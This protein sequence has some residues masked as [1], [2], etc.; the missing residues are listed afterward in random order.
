VNSFGP[1]DTDMIRKPTI[2]VNTGELCD[3][4]FQPD[5]SIIPVKHAKGRCLTFQASWYSKYPWLHFSV[6]LQ[7]ILCFYCSRAP[8][9]PDSHPEPAFITKGFRNWRKA[10]EKFDTHQVSDFHRS[11]VNQG[12]ANTSVSALLVKG[13]KDRQSFARRMLLMLMTSLRFLARQGLAVR[14][15]EDKNGNFEQLLLLRQGDSEELVRWMKR[16]HTFTSPAIQNE[17]LGL[18]AHS[19]IRQI[20]SEIRNSGSFSAIVDGTQ[21]CN[22]KEQESICIRYVDKDLKPVELFFGLYNTDSTTGQSLS[23]LILDALIRLD[24][25]MRMVRGQTYDGASNMS[26]IY[27]GAQSLIRQ[28]C[29]LATFVHCGSHCTNLVAQQACESSPVVRNA[30]S[31]V[32]ELG[33]LMHQSGKS[34]AVLQNIIS[35][36][37]PV[38]IEAI[39]PLCPTRWTIRVAAITTVLGQL[40]CLLD[41]LNEISTGNGDTAI[42]AR[43]LCDKFSSGDTILALLM[44]LVVFEPLEE[45]CKS[46][47]ARTQTVSGMKQAADKV[48]AFLQTRRS[49]E[50]FSSVYANANGIIESEELDEITVPRVRKAPKRL[51]DGSAPHAAPTPEAHYRAEYYKLVDS[52]I[53]QLKDRFSQ[54]GIDDVM[55]MESCLLQKDANLNFLEKYPEIDISRL[56]VQLQ[57]FQLDNNFTTIREAADFLSKLSPECSQMLSQVE[58]LIRLLL[59]IPASSA[60]AERSFSTLR[61]LKTW[62]RATMTQARLNFL[63]VLNVHSDILDTLNLLDVAEQFVA[64]HDSRLE[65]FGKFATNKS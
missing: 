53:T 47:Q 52:A 38:S 11:A 40:R 31:L 65:L 8:V 57:M 25:P 41:A 3:K 16:S 27:N 15:H 4:P 59:V 5:P 14:G 34:K 9:S 24:L 50:S 62:L 56:R 29:P 45:L 12:Q 42:R 43:G 30:L 13:N 1:N 35:S 6:T 7:R 63:C 44:A 61:R 55:S 19:V 64:K 36:V 23:H 58:V 51:D 33:V 48:I 28:T 18:M 54:P 46:L 32:N 17:I 39:R 2:Q 10:I 37:N 20:T 22:H 60:E 49:E 21:D 26:G